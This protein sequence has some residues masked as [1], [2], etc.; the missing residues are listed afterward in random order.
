[1]WFSFVQ[2]VRRNIFRKVNEGGIALATALAHACKDAFIRDV[3]LVALTTLAA[4][5]STQSGSSGG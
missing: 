1:M 5:A 2:E 3:H 4:A